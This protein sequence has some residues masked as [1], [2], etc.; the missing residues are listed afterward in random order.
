[1]ELTELPSEAAE[2]L[3]DTDSGS[4][5]VQAVAEAIEVLYFN[6]RRPGCGVSAEVFLT[7]TIDGRS[8]VVEVTELGVKSY[9]VCSAQLQ[10]THGPRRRYVVASKTRGGWAIEQRVWTEGG[11][12]VDNLIVTTNHHPHTREI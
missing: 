11:G 1:M 3:F 5:F 7:V 9:A 2:V 6:L 10:T 12:G 4:R 8:T